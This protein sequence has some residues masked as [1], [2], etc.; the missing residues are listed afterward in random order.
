[1]TLFAVACAGM[2]PIPPW[3]AVARL[4]ALPLPEHDGHVAAIPQS[5]CLGRLR[6]FDIRHRV[7]L[8]WYVGLIPDPATLRD[9]ANQPWKQR[10]FGMMA[11][12]WRGSAHHWAALRDGLP[13]ARGPGHAAGRLGA[14]RCELRF[15][16]RHR[17][18]LAH[19]HL[20]ALF[21]RGRDLLR[22]CHGAHARIP[23]R[24]FYQPGRFH[25]YAPPG[26]HG[27]GDA[28]HR[29]DCGLWL[30]DGGVF[31]FLQRQP[32]RIVHDEEPR[33]WT[34]RAVLLG[35]APCE[36]PDPAGIVVEAGSAPIPSHC[37]SC[38]SL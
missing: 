33:R 25:Y 32:V 21:C 9:R 35:L 10:V 34:L 24:K 20:S 13:A 28:R 11:M 36:C 15:R 18:R 8:F 29:S 31:R 3:P 12:G 30:R 16:G 27:E 1:M 14:H 6:R 7:I 37:F 17:P 22:I 5:P 26:K 2:F 23:L 38:P 19:H 4:L